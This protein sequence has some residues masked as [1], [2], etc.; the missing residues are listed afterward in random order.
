M[1]IPRVGMIQPMLVVPSSKQ[2]ITNPR[3]AAK[4]LGALSTGLAAA[5]N[6]RGLRLAKTRRRLYCS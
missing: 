6:S 5:P 4:T 2:A 3:R 1:L